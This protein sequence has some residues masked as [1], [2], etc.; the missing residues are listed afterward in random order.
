LPQYPPK[1]YNRQSENQPWHIA[2]NRLPMYRSFLHSWLRNAAKQKIREGVVRSAREQ[3]AEKSP[4]NPADGESKPCELGFVFALGIESGGLED[5]LD[6]LT[7]SSGGGFA[8]RE[9]LLGGRRAVLIL[10]EAGRQNAAHATEI[11]IE[12]HRP[13]RVIS[14][15]LAGGL[16]PELKRND[17]LAADRLL[18]IDGGDVPLAMPT[19]LADAAAMPGVHRGALLTVDRMV[20]LPDDKR[21]LF[22]QYAAA[23]VDM[24]TFAAAEAC[25][26]LATPF[27]SVRVIN[28]AAADALPRD[29]ERLLD[30]QS[31][32]AR[33]GAALGAVWRRPSS[34]K[35]M[36]QLR[37]NALIASDRLAKF[38]AKINFDSEV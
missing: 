8:V 21:K 18:S 28:D 9:G 2:N 26:R 22:E 20:R 12:A 15:G 33:L 31:G 23:A 35:D 32:A 34:A 7:F 29:V 30:Q 14:A 25:Q 17:I 5:I 16:S 4:R 38:I 13:R 1:W 27:S 36:Y 6:G 11:L 37:E 3:F 10:S 24:E 19:G